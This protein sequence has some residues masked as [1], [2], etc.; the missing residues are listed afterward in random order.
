MENGSATGSD[1]SITSKDGTILKCV[2]CI[3]GIVYMNI[4]HSS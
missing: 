4:C 2:H 3:A 1:E